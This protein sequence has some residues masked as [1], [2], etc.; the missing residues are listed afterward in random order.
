MLISQHWNAARRDSSTA[1]QKNG[2]ND[3]R[4]LLEKRLKTINGEIVRLKQQQSAINSF[5]EKAPDFK[6]QSQTNMFCGST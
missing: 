1:F 5:L 3:I 2:R 6:K 4:R